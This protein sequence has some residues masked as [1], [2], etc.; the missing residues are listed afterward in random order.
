MEEAMTTIPLPKVDGWLVQGGEH[1]DFMIG[2]VGKANIF[3]A[4]KGN[5][6]INLE[7]TAH[8]NVLIWN[9]GDAGSGG[10]TDTILDFRDTDILDLRGIL[11]SSSAADNIS[12]EVNGNDLFITVDVGSGADKAQ[13]IVLENAAL[14]LGFSNGDTG[15]FAEL[16]QQIR[17]LTNS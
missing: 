1:D 8:S 4:G 10:T 11:D 17:I 13:N 6:I 15:G 9:K 2:D 14:D 3:V 16:E 5:D 7:D 12:F